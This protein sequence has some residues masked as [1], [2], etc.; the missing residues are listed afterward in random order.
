VR[1]PNGALG[2]VDTM[3]GKLTVVPG[4]ALGRADFEFF[5]WQGGSHRLIIRAGPNATAGPDQIAYWQPGDARIM[6]ATFRDPAEL[7]KIETG[8]AG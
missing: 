2:V 1:L 8:S 4:T 5:D 6:V 3:S 7:S